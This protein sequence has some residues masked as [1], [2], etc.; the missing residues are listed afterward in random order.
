MQRTDGN[1]KLGSGTGG[2]Y[3]L[4]VNNLD[5][6]GLRSR[7]VG[8]LG[9][10]RGQG[11]PARK[12]QP[13]IKAPDPTMAKMYPFPVR[14]TVAGGRRGVGGM[15]GWLGGVRRGFNTATPLIA[16][17]NTGYVLGSS[18]VVVVRGVALGAEHSTSTDRGREAREM[19][20]QTLTRDRHHPPPACFASVSPPSRC[21][22]CGC[23][24]LGQSRPY[25][26]VARQSSVMRRLDGLDI[27]GVLCW[28]Q[29]LPPRP[30]SPVHTMYTVPC[31]CLSR[32][33]PRLGLAAVFVVAA[34][35]G[36]RARKA[37]GRLIIIIIRICRAG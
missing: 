35:P 33:Q 11:P 10:K 21:R 17:R 31:T 28:S 12:R 34:L 16:C 7:P 26:F 23:V 9:Q 18:F 20:M 13:F 30:P 1:A 5:P 8:W 4:L 19:Q 22:R 15:V 29:P 37:G 6:T 24:C 2:T 36:E 25:A 3:P 27:G 14:S 32:R